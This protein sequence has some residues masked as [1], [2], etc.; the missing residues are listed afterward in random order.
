[1]NDQRFIISIK[2][3]SADFAEGG[4]DGEESREMAVRLEAA[5]VDLIEL[6]G[7]T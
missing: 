6:S 2:I 5:G 7:G 3:N 1:V 4:F